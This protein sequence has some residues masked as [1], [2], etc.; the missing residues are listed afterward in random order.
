MQNMTKQFTYTHTSYTMHI[1]VAV[2]EHT[3]FATINLCNDYI[4]EYEY[5]S[6]TISAYT[7]V[8]NTRQL[9]SDV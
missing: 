9:H 3:E 1:Y 8:L 7:M 6:Q 2:Y 5:T 4:G